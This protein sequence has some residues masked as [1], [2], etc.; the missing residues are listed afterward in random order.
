[1]IKL[2]KKKIEEEKK[3]ETS[4]IEG[5]KEK[6]TESIFGTG[7]GKRAGEGDSKTVVKRLKPGEIRIQ[8]GKCLKTYSILGK[9]IYLRCSLLS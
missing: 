6:T 9:Y 1:M 2:G 5:E 7:G 3:E 4:K 8:K